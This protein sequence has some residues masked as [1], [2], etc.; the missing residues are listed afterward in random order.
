MYSNQNGT[1]VTYETWMAALASSAC[2]GLTSLVPWLFNLTFFER[3][4]ADPQQPGKQLEDQ[5]ESLFRCYATSFSAVAS[6]LH[7]FGW[8]YSHS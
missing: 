2:I 4:K 6:K 7:S 8:L 5:G 3:K 1:Y